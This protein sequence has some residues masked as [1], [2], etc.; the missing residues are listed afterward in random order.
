[1][2][3]FFTHK[4]QPEHNKDIGTIGIQYM[5]PYYHSKFDKSLHMIFKIEPEFYFWI[6]QFDKD[7][8]FSINIYINIYLSF[9]PYLLN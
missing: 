1:M 2:N 4:I 6:E 3:Y 5:Y 9:P 8:I 7:E